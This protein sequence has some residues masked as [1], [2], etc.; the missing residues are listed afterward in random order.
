MKKRRTLMVFLNS[1]VLYVIQVDLHLLPILPKSLESYI[2]YAWMKIHKSVSFSFLLLYLKRREKNME[3]AIWWYFLSF[4]FGYFSVKRGR[5][6]KKEIMPTTTCI[7]FE[8][9]EKKREEGAEGW[10]EWMKR[11]SRETEWITRWRRGRR[12]FHQ[13][14]F[15]FH[16]NLFLYFSFS[17]FFIWMAL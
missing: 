6:G 11:S 9:V 5:E 15:L 7:W 12:R 17:L 4:V 2:R 14:F 1:K 3:I 10:W 13:L 8:G 16:S